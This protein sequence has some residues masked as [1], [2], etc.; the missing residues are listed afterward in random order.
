MEVNL[1]DQIMIIR[2][3]YERMNEPRAWEQFETEFR[4]RILFQRELSLLLT[5]AGYANLRFYGDYDLNPWEPHSPRLISVCE[6][7]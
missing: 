1:P 4:F 6:K 5:C 7:P 2:R 3:L